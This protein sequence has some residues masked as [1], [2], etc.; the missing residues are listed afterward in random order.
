MFTAPDLR[1][2]RTSSGFF[3]GER[4]KYKLPREI[5]PQYIL[6]A[7][8]NIGLAA[9]YF[10][11]LFPAAKI[12]CCEPS[13][14]NVKLA[15]RNTAHLPDVVTLKCGLAGKSGLGRIKPALHAHNH[16]G[17]TIAET[18]A[19]DVPVYDYPRLLEAAGVPFFDLLKID[20]EGAE[21]PFLKS[22][23]DAALGRCKWIVGEVHGSDEWLLMDMLSKRFAVD[24]KKT[25]LGKQSKFHACNLSEIERLLRDFDVSILQK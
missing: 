21:Y 22:V 20:I 14:E 3:C 13:E 17:L 11:D 4:C 7:G 16:S 5:A 10:S 24:I 23:D 8:S 15:R 6:N 25:M 9:L 19:G 2:P 12:I 18:S 1:T